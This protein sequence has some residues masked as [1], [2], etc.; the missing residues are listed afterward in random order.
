MTPLPLRLPLDAVP[1]VAATAMPVWKRALDL[2]CCAL[3]LPL[4]GGCALV[5]ALVTVLVSPG[6]IFF[7]Q[8]RLGWRGKRFWIL[9][10]RTMSVNADTR[11]HQAYVQG[12][13]ASNAPM[14]KLDGRRDT[15]LIPGGWLLRASGMDELPQLLNV[16]RGDMSLVGPRPCLPA[17]FEH[18]HRP[19]G[20]RFAAVPG[21]TGLWQ[22]SGKNRT[23]FQEMIRLDVHYAHHV[24]LPLDLKIIVL[25]P[26]V[27][28]QQIFEA[29]LSRVR[30]R[31]EPP[32]CAA[33]AAPIGI[34][35][36]A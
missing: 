17:E 36:P 11:A 3:A 9:K 35:P 28:L 4:L 30:P 5:M 16:L 7:R 24:S 6:P 29:R 27:L 13:V 22:V 12:L 31:R 19:P 34:R 25:T 14:A 15:R 1:G 20:G 10:F 2:S 18:A 26:V 21:L 8:E 23:T 32:V 33:P